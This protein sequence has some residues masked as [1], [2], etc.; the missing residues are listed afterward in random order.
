M[1]E[2]EKGGADIINMSL[3][4]PSSSTA[5]SSKVDQLASKGIQ[6]VAAS[7]NSGSESNAMEFPAGYEKVISV[8][9]V[10]A[11]REIAFFS[12]HNNQVDVSAPGLDILSLTQS[13]SSCYAE[14]SGT[15]MASPHVAGAFA[16]LKSKYPSKSISDIRE[17]LEESASDSGACGVDR[18]FGHGIIDVM[19]AADYLENG[20]SAPELTGCIG[21]K[22]TLKTDKWGAETSYEIRNAEGEVV[23]KNGPYENT[24]DTYTD[25]FQLPEGCYEFVM[26]DS[27][28]T[29]N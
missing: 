4:G 15:S 10:D 28:G 26:L 8:G 5:E 14:Y 20:G 13:C 6:L 2:C 9:A 7:G 22:V 18:M 21:I 12:T 29:F 23:Y 11:N 3:G 27:Y 17:A 25:E 16:L 24:E 1:D 19:A